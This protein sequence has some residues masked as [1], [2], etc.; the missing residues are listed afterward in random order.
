MYFSTWLLPE[1]F[2][3]GWGSKLETGKCLFKGVIFHYLKLDLSQRF[4]L[5]IVCTTISNDSIQGIDFNT[6]Q[7]QDFL[8]KVA[9][10]ISLSD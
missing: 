6:L 3:T 1:D 5:P 10:C 9:P 7:S 2:G 4:G 8:D